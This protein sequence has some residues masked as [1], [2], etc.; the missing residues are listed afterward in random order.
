MLLIV[1]SDKLRI[2]NHVN[3][4]CRMN[5]RVGIYL[6]LSLKTAFRACRAMNDKSL[7][8]VAALRVHIC[9]FRCR[10]NHGLIVNHLLA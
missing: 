1:R 10:I 6:K 3:A 8:G 7:E 5:C 4:Y 9:K 2:I